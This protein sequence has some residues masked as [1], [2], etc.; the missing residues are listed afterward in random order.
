M[1]MKTLGRARWSL[2]V[3]FRMQY[4]KRIQKFILS[5]TLMENWT[6]KTEGYLWR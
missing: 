1:F 4:D 5:H 2:E 3:I 6:R